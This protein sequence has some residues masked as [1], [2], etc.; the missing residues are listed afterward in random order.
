MLYAI[1][2]YHVEAEVQSWT[3]AEDAALMTE[4]LGAFSLTALLL[5]AIGIYGVLS[6]T[7][8]QRRQ[9]IG[10]RLAI[11]SP[12]SGIFKL[13]LSQGMRLTLIGVLMGLILALAMGRVLGSLLYEISASD[14]V[15]F[16]FNAV[17]L[18][19]IALLA[20]WIPAHRASRTD[21]IIALR[22][23]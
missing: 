8:S 10:I 6:Y 22:A 11:G 23:E 13:I 9:E 7:V 16:A 21:P 3:P 5:A 4:L 20:C 12:V 19:G 1:L 15:T 18:I 17:L 2:A 14:P